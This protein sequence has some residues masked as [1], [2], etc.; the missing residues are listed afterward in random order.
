MNTIYD[1]RILHASAN[2]T[3]ALDEAAYARH[4]EDMLT[5]AEILAALKERGVTQKAIANVLGVQQPNAATLYTP[6]KNGKLRQ[7]SYDEG[8]ALIE[9]FDLDEGAPKPKAA[10]APNATV[11]TSTFAVLLDSLGVD[12]FE[13]GRAQK[14]AARFPDALRSMSDLQAGSADQGLSH[15]EASR[16]D[17][18]DRPPA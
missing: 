1:S 2:T 5:A 8:V 9:A 14:L 10:P 13:D 11:L 3:F 12:P 16:D 15:G 4:A 6:A 18:E 17:G 7:L